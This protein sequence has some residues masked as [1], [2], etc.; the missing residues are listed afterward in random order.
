[1]DNT[2]AFYFAIGLTNAFAE[3]LRMPLGTVTLTDFMRL[4]ALLFSAVTP[5][6]GKLRS[7]GT[8]V[9]VFGRAAAASF[10]ICS[11]MRLASIQ[12]DA[13]MRSANNPLD[14]ITAIVFLHARIIYIQ[15]AAE[16][17]ECAARVLSDLQLRRIF[18]QTDLGAWPGNESYA[19]ALTEGARGDLTPI[20][21][22]VNARL[23]ERKVVLPADCA[24]QSPFDVLSRNWTAL[25]KRRPDL[26]LL[27]CSSRFPSG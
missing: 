18:D 15:P 3:F 12:F 9:I 7:K 27:L 19:R 6:A 1:M 10:D 17:N 22:L 20:V 26:E 14:L 4:H 8:E 13:L 25:D 5:R 21:R 23:K 2:S 11:E 16:G 24:M